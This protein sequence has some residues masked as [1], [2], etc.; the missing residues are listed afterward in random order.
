[1]RKAVT[2]KDISA[3]TGVSL[4]SVHRALYQKEGVSGELCESILLKVREL[5][6]KANYAAASLKRKTLNVA[7]ALPGGEGKGRMY[8]RYMWQACGDYNKEVAGL[9]IQ[10]HNFPVSDTNYIKVLEKIYRT[11]G[12]NLNGLLLVPLDEGNET[13][14]IIDKFINRGVQ[15][16]LVDNDISGCRRLCCISPHDEST[17]RLGA[18]ILSAF[19]SRPGKILV[20]AGSRT[21]A[22][23]VNNVMGFSAYIKENGFPFSIDYIH[24]Y[25]DAN[26]G[27]SEAK[28]FLKSH[29]DIVAFYVVSA[30]ETVPLC[31]A[32]IDSGYAGKLRGVGS[33]IFPESV[34]MLKNDV[35]QA[36]IY[37]NPYEKAYRGLKILCEALIKKEKPE[38]SSVSVPIGIIMKNNLPFFLEFIR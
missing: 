36:L 16:V 5:G 13:A 25:E 37:K 19:T 2:L 1:M 7:I 30:R 12:D 18:E 32:V 35:V 28:S 9:N 17:G 26:A 14:G 10:L 29:D 24:Q 33:D 23:H 31:Q 11:C 22:S 21:I 20:S 27:Y 15:V 34:Q 38:S 3:A 8:Y 6:Y 4:A